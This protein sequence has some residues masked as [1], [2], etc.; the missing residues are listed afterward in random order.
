[1]GIIKTL[2]QQGSE[3]SKY[4]GKTP[5]DER[6][7]R[8]GAKLRLQ[9][10]ELSR[11][12]GGTPREARFP[13]PLDSSDSYLSAY[14][15]L[16]P[17]PNLLTTNQS[18]LLYP[19]SITGEAR[20]QVQFEYGLYSN[21]ATAV[22]PLP[23]LL[24]VDIFATPLSYYYDGTEG[25]YAK[26]VGVGT[27]P[28]RQTLSD[29]TL[30]NRLTI[31][32]TAKIANQNLG[33][34][35]TNPFGIDTSTPPNILLQYNNPVSSP[36]EPS[37]EFVRI[38]NPTIRL[39]D[40]YDDGKAQAK[41]IFDN[42]NQISPL[43]GQKFDSHKE[44][45]WVYNP[46]YGQNVGASFT[47][48]VY[49]SENGGDDDALFKA[50]F[51]DDY[52]TNLLNRST[53]IYNKPLNNPK[54]FI[55]YISDDPSKPGYLTPEIT[56]LSSGSNNWV[57]NPLYG[58]GAGASFAYQTFASEIGVND[59]E[60]FK[61]LFTDDYK[62]NILDRRDN[63]VFFDTKLQENKL[64]LANN[65]TY[66][67]EQLI[68]TNTS[69]ASNSE[70]QLFQKSTTLDNITDYRAIIK[71][72]S[73]SRN[74]DTLPST[75][76]KEFNREF[77]Y[78]AN[79]TRFANAIYARLEGDEGGLLNNPNYTAYGNID[80][81]NTVTPNDASQ[82]TGET[83]EEFKNA[84]LVKFFFEINNNDAET[85]TA[86]W[87]LFFRAYINNFGD[88]F[89]SSWQ[90]YK[91]IGRGENFYKYTGFTREISLD[92]TIYA[93]TRVEMIPLYEKLNYLVGTL[94]PDYSKMGYMRGNFVNL[95]VGDY[96]VNTPGIIKNISLKP[97][98]ETGWDLNRDEKGNIIP[99]YKKPYFIDGEEKANYFVGQLP[100][101]IDVTLTFT[102]IHNFTPR[103]GSSF[104]RN[105]VST[106]APKVEEANID[107]ATDPPF[108]PEEKERLRR[109][110]NGEQLDITGP[111][112]SFEE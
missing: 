48:Q 83:L 57:Y 1:M 105:Y 92:F 96:L 111:P 38:Q 79:K 51:T 8:L 34:L 23:T 101:L 41:A 93:H 59:D 30:E 16:T 107:A 88:N 72:S 31:A 103:F 44:P 32:Y 100:R 17:Q 2:K 98:L 40:L 35:E 25:Y 10:S 13:D 60:L 109:V 45:V 90:E 56:V 85:N 61:V 18:P 77:T 81:L 19:Y 14:K 7:A 99:S 43:P 97:S 102:P 63:T 53:T 108:T 12:D 82:M 11:Y 4:D 9:G 37:L 66:T 67:Y 91:Y 95:T 42:P 106:T 74:T 54:L 26:T 84:D 33:A 87:F 112:P 46:L 3:L 15:G 58:S 64:N 94:A 55:K 76:Y 71:A 24:G 39:E 21:G 20:G 86:N 27:N 69:P 50:L 73:S 65:F 28:S 75:N 62:L 22:L 80:V 89:N 104:I 29:G 110:S 68:K 47:Y 78:K 6:P 52:K 49:A 5:R 36:E 70:E